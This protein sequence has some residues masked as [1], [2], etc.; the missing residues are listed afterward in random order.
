MN[1]TQQQSQ[2]IQTRGN[3]AFQMGTNLT[4]KRRLMRINVR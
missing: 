4:K 1:E 3:K 2:H